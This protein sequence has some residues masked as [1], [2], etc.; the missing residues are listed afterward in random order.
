VRKKKPR[1]FVTWLALWLEANDISV[2]RFSRSILSSPRTVK[3]WIS[4]R[5]P[6]SQHLSQLTL[7]LYPDCPILRNG[8]PVRLLSECLPGNARRPRFY[9]Y[10]FKRLGLAPTELD[11]INVWGKAVEMARLWD[12]CADQGPMAAGQ[13]DPEGIAD[14]L[15]PADGGELDQDG[16]EEDAD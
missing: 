9:R 1:P 15:P 5:Q 11:P 10:L 14:V 16:G 6:M 3:T 12:S 4:G 7:A 2:E 13:P 8:G